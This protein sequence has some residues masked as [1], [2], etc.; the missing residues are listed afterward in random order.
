M[1]TYNQLHKDLLSCDNFHSLSRY[2]TDNTSLK[3]CHLLGKHYLLSYVRDIR[4][5][6]M[7]DY[8]FRILCWGASM[9]VLGVGACFMQLDI[10]PL[11]EV[12][13]NYC[14]FSLNVRSLVSFG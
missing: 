12:L 6:Q 14:C 1:G 5:K 13:S 11:L 3:K 10:A 8:V 2:A 4:I 7:L 9:F